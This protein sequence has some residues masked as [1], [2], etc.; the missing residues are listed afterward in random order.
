MLQWLSVRH[1]IIFVN[2]YVSWIC[3]FTS[4]CELHISQ[5]PVIEISL[6]TKA[7][8][9]SE[10]TDHS[11]QLLPYELLV[12]TSYQPFYLQLQSG[13]STVITGR[14]PRLRP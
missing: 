6:T 1:Y 2:P 9:I 11:W 14:K 10:E 7:H 5:A 3:C 13:T 8:P 12:V 4:K